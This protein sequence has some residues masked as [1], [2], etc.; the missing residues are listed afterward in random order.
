MSDITNSAG[1]V[2]SD[3]FC[4]NNLENTPCLFRTSILNMKSRL[5][6]EDTIKKQQ[7]Q[8]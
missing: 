7:S 4:T 2:K 8:Q 5:L 1:M 3:Y 6:L